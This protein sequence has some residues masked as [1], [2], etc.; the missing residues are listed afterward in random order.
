MRWPAS[1]LWYRCRRSS[2]GSGSL[3]VDQVDVR[4]SMTAA[5]ESG[6][7]DT[8]FNLPP[9]R[10]LDGIKIHVPGSTAN[11]CL[12]PRR[13]SYISLL[14]NQPPYAGPCGIILV[15][16]GCFANGHLVS[17]SLFPS[18]FLFCFFFFSLYFKFIISLTEKNC[19]NLLKNIIPKKRT[20]PPIV[21]ISPITIWTHY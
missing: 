15:L 11:A 7:P 17:F 5:C 14:A 20:I 10:G 21:S 4:L 1:C 19:W 12:Y 8:I 2:R 3:R 13:R 16:P 18:F 9:G 6:D